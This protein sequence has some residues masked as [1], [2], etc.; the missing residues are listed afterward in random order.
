MASSAGLRKRV[1]AA[2]RLSAADS[3]TTKTSPYFSS[4][5][6]QEPPPKKPRKRPKVEVKYEKSETTPIV[7][8]SKLSLK[9]SPSKK[10]SAAKV[11]AHGGNDSAASSSSW[12]PDRFEEH[13]DKICEMRKA[14]NAPVDSMGAECCQDKTAPDNVSGQSFLLHIKT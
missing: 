2:V 7:T 12:M 8:D 3:L 4:D 6:S 5:C 1:A 11:S 10:S 9:V 13:Y 14:R